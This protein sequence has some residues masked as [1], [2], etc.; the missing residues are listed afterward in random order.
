M[1]ETWMGL[2][3]GGAALGIAMLM[4]MAHYRRERARARMLRNMDHHEW[5]HQTRGRR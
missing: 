1:S 3:I 4:A 2:I 5:W